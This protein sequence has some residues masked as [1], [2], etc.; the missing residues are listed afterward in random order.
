[1]KLIRISLVL[2]SF[3]VTTAQ[4]QVRPIERLNIGGSNPSS[5]NAQDGVTVAAMGAGFV[6]AY[7]EQ[8]GTTNATTDIYAVVST[9]E[10]LSWS[11][12]ARVDRG[13]A[14]NATDSELPKVAYCSDGV[15]VCVWEDK[16][17]A[18]ANG[19]NNEDVFFNR[20]LDGG[21]N[22]EPISV[23]L[24]TDTDQNHTTSDVDR[25]AMTAEGTNVYVVWEEDRT[26]LAGAEDLYFVVSNDSGATF[27]APVR[28]TS[29]ILGSGS[30]G[31]HNDADDPAI[32]AQGNDVAIVF[33][34]DRNFAQ[35]DIMSLVSNDGGQTWVESPIETNT[36]GDVDNPQI[37]VTDIG[38]GVSGFLVAWRDEGMVAGG[39][40]HTVTSI[41]GG[42]SWL[43]EQNASALVVGA[44]PA[45]EVEHISVDFG[46]GGLAYAAWVS[47][48]L[49]PAVG[50]GSNGER[51]AFVASSVNFG[52]TWQPE[53]G[54][55]AVNPT[56]KNHFTR[57]VA[58]GSIAY[59]HFETGNFTVN[60]NAIA[61]SIDGGLSWQTEYRPAT[62][63]T[64]SPAPLEGHYFAMS[65]TGGAAVCGF[66]SNP[67]GQ[68]EIYAISLR[69]PF[70]V[71]NGNSVFGQPASFG[72]RAIPDAVFVPFFGVLVSVTGS[73]PALPFG[74]SRLLHLVPDDVTS[75]GLGD[76]FLNVLLTGLVDPMFAAGDTPVSPAILPPG[77]TCYCAALGVNNS[78]AIDFHTDPIEITGQ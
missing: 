36:T 24:N 21:L 1:M 41:D 77:E 73:S 44:Q 52:L 58:Q 61:Y 72:A 68:N 54:L 46:G 27:T 60:D 43:S 71:E 62:G 33:V 64:D 42:V 51:K 4:A 3:I 70:M 19:S 32:A 48:V 35:D 57:V 67:S 74:E 76:N 17:D 15:A 2:I 16:R 49:N 55:D 28:L 10:G 12:P 53:I 38:L 40:V 22:W 45:E 47:D 9:D 66:L 20:S 5:A 13:D 26:Q 56:Q 29:Q 65:K 18:A 7:A 63:D 31:P 23:A 8:N 50:A 39:Q 25:I 11:A 78:G 14:L 59:V 69:V 37:A 34:D 6:V 30:V 75:F